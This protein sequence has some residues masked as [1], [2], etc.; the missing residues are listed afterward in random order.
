LLQPLLLLSVVSLDGL[1]SQRLL[2]PAVTLFLV[3][4][5]RL[6]DSGRPRER[7]SEAATAAKGLLKE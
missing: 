5:L 1:L 7:L 3:L 2:L 4:L 6:G